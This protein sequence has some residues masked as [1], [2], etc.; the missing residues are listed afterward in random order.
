VLFF[1]PGPLVEAAGHGSG[2]G[3]VA[4]SPCHIVTST[5]ISIQDYLLPPFF[6]YLISTLVFYLS[7]TLNYISGALYGFITWISLVAKEDD[8]DVAPISWEPLVWFL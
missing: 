2:Y 7:A 6:Q 4:V 8:D 1:D 3:L 5:T